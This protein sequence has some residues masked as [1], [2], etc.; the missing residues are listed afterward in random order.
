M[1][2]TPIEGQTNRS[3]SVNRTLEAD[4]QI[5]SVIPDLTVSGRS[6]VITGSASDANARTLLNV[7]E[8]HFYWQPQYR[9]REPV[10]F[11]RGS[12]LECSATFHHPLVDPN[13][14]ALIADPV[15][16]EDQMVGYFEV[17]P[18]PMDPVAAQ[19]IALADPTRNIST[20][21]AGLATTLLFCLVFLWLKP[22]QRP[23]PPPIA[24]VA[25]SSP[26]E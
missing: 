8:Y 19:A 26:T 17:V 23:V 7:P 18:P 20:A 12:T 3:S 1:D 9:F 22:T 6:F 4:L 25:T 14:D 15:V 16:S 2:I 11:L 24:P 5:L 13:S 21:I 10:P